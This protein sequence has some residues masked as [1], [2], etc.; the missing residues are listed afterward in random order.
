MN[1]HDAARI[2]NLSGE[3]NPDTVK[4]AYRQACSKFH[5]D[6]NPAGIEMMK[7]VNA[8]YE[9]LKDFTGKANPDSTEDY[10]N[11]LNA[12]I[13]FALALAGIMVE[14]CGA[15]VWLSGDTKVHREALKDS[16]HSLPDGNGYRWAP[17][18]KMWYYRPSE[19]SSWGR[20]SWTMDDIRAEHGSTK[21]QNEKKKIATA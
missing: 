17:K 9:V 13:E 14:V 15:W 4:K 12:A 6:R 11:S 1:V 5:P 18:K 16:K 21:V 19:W 20:G 10:G 3:I 2:L 7:A 8:A